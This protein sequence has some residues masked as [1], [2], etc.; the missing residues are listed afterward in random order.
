MLFAIMKTLMFAIETISPKTMVPVTQNYSVE[1]FFVTKFDS[2]EYRE[3]IRIIPDYIVADRN[4]NQNILGIN[5]LS[6]YII[7][8]F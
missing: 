7:Y 5:S 3:T 2:K 4:C 6:C 8:I 1:P